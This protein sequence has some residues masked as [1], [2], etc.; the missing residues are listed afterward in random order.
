MWPYL[1]MFLIP[2]TAA[3]AGGDRPISRMPGR[4][5]TRRLSMPWVFATAIFALMVG[6]R[7]EVGG[8]WFNYLTLLETVSIL[9][10]FEAIR[11][12][13]PGYY[14]LTLISAE[15][16]W[17]VY[18]VN[19]FCGLVFALGLSAFCRGLPRPWL[20]LAVATPYLVIV[21]AMGYTRQAVALSLAMLGLRALQRGATSWFVLCV[22]L[23]ATFHKSAVL[24]LPIAALAGSRNRYWNVLWISVVAFGAYVLLLE[25]SVGPMY[26]NYVEAEYQSE[27]A[28]V[29]GLMNALPATLLLL[30]WKNFRFTTDEKGL[31]FWFA[32]ISMALLGVLAVTSASAAV[33]RLALYMLPLQLVVF[34]HLPEVLG[35]QQ[36]KNTAWA[37]AVVMYYA[38]VLL[39]W[40]NFATHAEYWK[41]YRFYPLD[42]LL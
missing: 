12:P 25:E 37:T 28:W 1:L 18:I 3:L 36:G 6:L 42:R 10:L 19:L 8:D 34:S 13:D 30:R 22:L 40:M 27:G 17:G 7:N 9:P 32:V 31:W 11:E 33:D 16:G 20:A 23:G 4:R 5:R 2:A 39:V 24:L 29:R 38:A 35:S 41:P 14:L 21:V 26:V 15:L